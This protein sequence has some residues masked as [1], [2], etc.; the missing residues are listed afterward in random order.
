MELLAQFWSDLATLGFLQRA[1][2]AGAVVAAVC[3][4]V[5]LFLTVRRLSLLGECLAHVSLAGAAVGAVVGTNI[6]LSVLA[7]TTLAAVALEGM[8]RAYGRHADLALA[9]TTATGLGVTAVVVGWG[10]LN[11]GVVSG[12]LFGSLVAVAPSDVGTIVVLGLGLLFGLALAY[13]PL[14]FLA[15][16]E[17]GARAAGIPVDGISLGFLVLAGVAVGLAMR[18]VGALLLASLMILP[19]ASALAWARSFRQALAGSVLLGELATSSGLVLAYYLDTAPGGTIVLTSV[20]ILVVIMAAK[21][22]LGIRLG[23]GGNDS[24]HGSKS[25]EPARAGAIPGRQGV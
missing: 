10:R 25:G 3:P 9:V 8:R 21:A 16:D 20:L 23:R 13:R 12:Y 2:L 14:L 24:D 1:F 15:L 6:G 19:V 22:V 5:G 17:E 4:A 11:L 18:L 7:T